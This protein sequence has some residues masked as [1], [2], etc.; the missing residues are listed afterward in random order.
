MLRARGTAVTTILA[1]SDDAAPG[2]AARLTRSL[3]QSPRPSG[4]GLSC[5]SGQPHAV[6][7]ER[8]SPEVRERAG[9]MVLA[10]AEEL[11]DAVEHPVMM[12]APGKRASA[13]ERLEHL[14]EIDEA[15]SDDA[16]S[17]RHEH[18]RVLVREGQAGRGG[19][20][21]RPDGSCGSEQPPQ[22][23]GTDVPNQLLDLRR[24]RQVAVAGEPVGQFGHEGM[25]PM[26]ADVSGGLPQHLDGGGH[27][28]AID[29]GPAARDGAVGA[30]GARRSTR[31]AALRC[32][33]VTAT[34]SS[35]STPFSSG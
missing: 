5:F 16:L 4:L 27:G 30:R 6:R 26:R 12:G 14:V 3:T 11:L 2:N 20:A 7:P 21:R 32:R 31:M 29:P 22:G 15:R 8:C 25:E 1:G 17:R 23:G 28:G 9:R 18:R 34:T 13:P 19:T 24:Q 10:R 35:S 33:P